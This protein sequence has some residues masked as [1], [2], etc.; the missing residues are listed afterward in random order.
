MGIVEI[1]KSTVPVL[2]S[3]GGKVSWLAPRGIYYLCEFQPD[4]Q[5]HDPKNLIILAQSMQ[6]H[7]SG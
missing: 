3:R 2:H 7:V 6:S 4:S 1:Q 5:A